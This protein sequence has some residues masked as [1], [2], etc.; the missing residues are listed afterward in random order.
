R[1]VF[2]PAN[3]GR[4]PL[5]IYLVALSVSWLGRSPLAIR[6]VAALLGI[7]TIPA[8]YGMVREWLGQREAQ[9]AAVSTAITF[10]HLNLSRVGFRAVCLPLFTALCLWCFLHGQRQKQGLVSAL[11]GLLLGLAF[12]T[13]LAARF[14][15]IV[16]F[17]WVAYWLGRRQPV[18]WR[19]LLLF[20]ATALLV[21]APF[22]LYI[23]QHPDVLF[24]RSAQV[25]IF[26]ATVN[27]G[28]LIGT[29]ARQIVRTLAMFNWRGDFIPRHNLP[30]RPVF[31]P[32]IGLLF[33]AGVVIS[34]RRAGRQQEYGLLLLY[35]PIM[36]IPTILAEGAPHFL[37]AVGVLP[38]LF[39]FPA[40]ALVALWEELG[41][42]RSSR[43]AALAMV[44]V[45]AL[46]LSVTVNDYFR[47]HV[48][49]EATYFNFET[50]AVELA[51][52]INDFLGTGW[53][54]GAEQ[55]ATFAA[56][57]QRSVYL[58]GRLWSDWA[59]LRYLVP[60]TGS[61]VLLEEDIPPPKTP[62]E[63]QLVVWPYT[64][65]SQYLPLLPKER[66]ITVREGPQERGDLE[67]TSRLLCLIYSAALPQDVPGNLRA[68]F[69]Q[70]I[71]L[72]GYELETNASGAR[73]RLFWYTGAE[74]DADYTV[75][76]HWKR[77]EAMVAQSDS[78]PA[79]GHYPTH[80]WRVGDTVADEHL[81][82]ATTSPETGDTILV[83]LYQT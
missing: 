34:V 56:A 36:L 1:P 61:L 77:G 12:Y 33:L 40:V 63:A 49:S 4:E 14:L 19:G 21:A 45:I 2:F 80:L 17:V 60:E 18:Y 57:S 72:L 64:E 39:A 44:L 26:S 53:P 16:F 54:E 32:A 22:L 76:V 74:L 82:Q 70:G 42:R 37:R 67:Q 5:F 43:V 73:L 83:G 29:F 24:G 27:Q 66:L 3:Q 75:F 58:E 55:S 81:L 59:S 11:G 68:H 15:P 65:H 79:Q 69:E 20:C 48:R 31:D 71:E 6:L 62:S 25:S 35:V 13:Y 9:L 41:R 7:L 50:G 38:V 51:A 78:Y 52:D 10:W 8:T 46:S 47:R 23:Q 30:Y 28:D